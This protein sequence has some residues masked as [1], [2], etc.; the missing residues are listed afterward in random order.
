MKNFIYFFYYIK[1]TDY[2]LLKE[3]L[4]RIS[5][6][7]KKPLIKIICQM[8]RISLK[9]GASFNDFWIYK[10][11]KMKDEEIDGYV[12]TGRLYEFYTSMNDKKY[13]DIFRNKRRF[14]EVFHQYIGREYQYIVGADEQKLI[15]WLS[16]RSNIIAK[17]NYGT[18]GKGIEKIDV[19]KWEKKA[20]LIK[21]L[22]DKNLYLIEDCVQQHES[23]NQI[24]PSSVNTIRIVTV[25]N[26]GKVDIIS[27][28]IRIGVNNHVDN[29]AAGGIAAPID[30]E[31]GIVYKPATNKIR[32]T[33]YVRHP[34]T[35][36]QILNFKIPYWKEII[37]M[38]NEVAW[39]VPEVKTVGWDVAITESGPII[40][41]GNDNWDKDVFQLPYNEG[42]QYILDKYI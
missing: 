24:N 41:E 32:S 12:T 30:I 8:V 11:Y 13:I 40:I 7:T 39:L 2:K 29:F 19:T 35:N 22:L 15:D 28:I 14:N 20:D 33:E 34:I 38:I 17:P 10:F 1:T 27:A 36:K 42:R 6:E 31:T 4:K 18:T 37:N 25:Q 5:K 21:Y 16:R 3:N 9:F 26:H 23:M